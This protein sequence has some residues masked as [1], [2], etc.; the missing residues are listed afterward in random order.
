MFRIDPRQLCWALE[1]LVAGKI[2][3]RIRVPEKEAVQAKLAL[4]RMLDVS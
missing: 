4:E 3:N 2:V 1:N